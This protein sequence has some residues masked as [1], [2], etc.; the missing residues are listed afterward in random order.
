V[1]HLCAA[2]GDPA[3]NTTLEVAR[4]LTPKPCPKW[5][6]SSSGLS[7]W[8]D[9]TL[10]GSLDPIWLLATAAPGAAQVSSSAQVY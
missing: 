10:D 9:V 3:T 1:R 4:G 6:T 2:Q 7:W 5:G 8:L